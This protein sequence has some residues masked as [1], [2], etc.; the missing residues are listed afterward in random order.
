MLTFDQ[1]DIESGE[2]YRINKIVN[3][4][5]KYA[6][7]VELSPREFVDRNDYFGLV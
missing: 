7:E 1:L 4:N 5:Q 3:L 2:F 6:T